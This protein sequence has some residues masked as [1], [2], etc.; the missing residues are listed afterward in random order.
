MSKMYFASDGSYGSAEELAVH[1]T[2]NWTDAMWE[3]IESATDNRRPSLSD[4]FAENKHELDGDKQC[5]ECGLGGSDL[6]PAND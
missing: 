3:E 4:H 5:V 1:D 6:P 2:E